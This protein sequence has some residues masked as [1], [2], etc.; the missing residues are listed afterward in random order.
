ME[1]TAILKG[2][3]EEMYL[4]AVWELGDLELADQLTDEQE[5][6]YKALYDAL[7]AGKI[8]AFEYY[9]ARRNPASYNRYIVAR[10]TRPGV[11]VQVS[12]VWMHDGDMLPMM[13]SDINCFD[14]FRDCIR[15]GDA[16]VHWLKL[17]AAGCV[18]C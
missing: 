14:D 12:T 18:A 17:P 9:D 2:L 4:K 15:Q 11:L 10:S 13:H 7:V 8:N 6:P 16:V 5:R 3:D 1:G